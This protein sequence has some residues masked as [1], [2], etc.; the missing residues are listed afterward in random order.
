MRRNS[1][2]A[3]ASII[4]Q[5]SHAIARQQ[6]LKTPIPIKQPL[7][8]ENQRVPQ[9]TTD[10]ESLKPCV[11]PQET[12]HADTPQP[13]VR[14]K[15]SA[16][17]STLAI[18]TDLK[19]VCIAITS[20]QLNAARE[21]S[22]ACY[23]AEYISSPTNTDDQPPCVRPKTCKVNLT[24]PANW[25]TRIIGNTSEVTTAI[26]PTAIV[27]QE[28]SKKESVETLGPKNSISPEGNPHK[29]AQPSSLECSTSSGSLRA[30]KN[31]SDYSPSPYVELV[32]LFTDVTGV[33]RDK[34]GFRIIANF[35]Y[36]LNRD[37]KPVIIKLRTDGEEFQH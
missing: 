11:E 10:T 26:N 16:E 37:S 3:S 18:D 23:G 30:W 31:S 4:H 35:C 36:T 29:K 9:G 2:A 5:S 24:F 13:C 33:V 34:S 7:E 22:E 27:E 28:D 14:L 19:N 15:A 25:S 6:L 32:S 1:Q 8:I 20:L 21:C 12:T 17:P